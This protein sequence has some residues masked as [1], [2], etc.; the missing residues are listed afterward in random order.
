MKQCHWG[1]HLL[2]HSDQPSAAH[3]VSAVWSSFPDAPSSEQ[4]IPK[5]K[6]SV[7]WWVKVFSSRWTFHDK[8]D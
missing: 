8:I 7:N 3:S 5:F 6:L 1:H 4:G 2:Q